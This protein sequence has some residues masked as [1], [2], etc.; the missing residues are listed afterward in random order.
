MPAP[1]GTQ[2]Q[3]EVLAELASVFASLKIGFWLRGGWALDFLL[4][5]IT[6]VHSDIDLVSWAR[7]RTRIQR[8][9]LA[10]EFVHVN[11]FPAQS[12][13]Q[14]HGAAISV[15]FIARSRQGVVT[16]AI[17][18]WR[19]RRGALMRRR[20]TLEGLSMRALAPIQL[21]DEKLTYGQGNGRPPW[22]AKDQVSV[23]ILQELLRQP[24]APGSTA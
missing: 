17:P 7:E 19:W 12:N 2:I 22:R 18:E 14:K 16:P 4:G 11:D 5:R 8:G 23:Q 1:D 13:F 3:L 21:L 20:L 6:R 24:R 10:H 15:V 9:L